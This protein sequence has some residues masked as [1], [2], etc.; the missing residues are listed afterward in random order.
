MS[1]AKGKKNKEIIIE[2]KNGSSLALYSKGPGRSYVKILDAD[3]SVLDFMDFNFFKRKYAEF[4]NI[5]EKLLADPISIDTDKKIPRKK[6]YKSIKEFFES[7]SNK[8][9]YR[10]IVAE[11]GYQIIMDFI[12]EM[13]KK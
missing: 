4:Y 1:M 2:S 6:L 9:E 8:D 7:V 13:D 12:E 5:P 3:G 11:P 10:G